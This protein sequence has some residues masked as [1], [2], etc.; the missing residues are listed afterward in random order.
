M[1]R[2]HIIWLGALAI[3]VAACEKRIEVHPT[4]PEEVVYCEAP[5][6]LIGSW[7][8]DSVR[9]TTKV[10]SIDSNQVDRFP[11]VRYAMRVDCGQGDSLFQ[12]SYQN[13]SGVTTFRVKSTNYIATERTVYIF[14]QLVSSA[15]TGGANFTLRLDSIVDGRMKAAWI[16]HPNDVQRT[17]TEIYFRKD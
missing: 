13:H 1:H 16:D 7:T 11:S 14:G 9:I 2:A 6:S 8:S 15:D 4:L 12:L 10:D 3:I 17:T 5:E